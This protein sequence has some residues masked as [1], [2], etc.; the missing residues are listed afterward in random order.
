MGKQLILDDNIRNRLVAEA[1]KDD[2][3]KEKIEKTIKN[4]SNLGDV[5]EFN[6][7]LKNDPK[8]GMDAYA[9][10]FYDKSI[11]EVYFFVRG[12]EV[13]QFNDIYA[14]VT[15]FIKERHITKLAE[16]A[17]YIF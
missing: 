8:S 13:D 12:T 9:I 4:N 1:Y 7:Y 6:I 5:P 15:G 14:D 10:H 2:I 17:N 16:C 3:N 11:N